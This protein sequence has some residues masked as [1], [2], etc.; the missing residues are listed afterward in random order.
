MKPTKIK[1][2]YAID[3]FFEQTDSENNSMFFFFKKLSD[4]IPMAIF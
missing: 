4:M 3:E 1:E 2:N